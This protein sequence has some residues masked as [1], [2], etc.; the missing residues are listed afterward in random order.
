MQTEELSANWKTVVDTIQEGVMIVDPSGTIVSVNQAL[1]EMTGFGAARPGRPFLRR[2]QLRLLPAGAC[3]GRAAL[4]LVVRK[5]PA[6]PPALQPGAPRRH[7]GAGAQERLGAARRRRPGD[8]RGGDDHRPERSART[9]HHHRGLPAGVGQPR[10][11][12]R[13]GRG[14][15][16]HAAVL[17]PA[18]QRRLLGRAPAAPGRVGHGQG[19]GRA[20]RARAQSAPR[21]A[22]RQGQLRGP[23]RGPARERAVRPRARRLH[24]RAPGTGRPVRGGL[25]RHHL[26][27]RDRRFARAHP[28]QAA[29]RARGAGDRAGGR[30][31]AGG[32]WTCA[33]SRPPTATWRPWCARARFARTCSTASTSC[34]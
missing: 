20:G 3:A 12:P 8:R 6:H 10:H 27:R 17:R 9:R 32:R 24:R 1:A 30:Q 4:V 18:R 19:A 14:Q 22:V 7:R 25:G 23:Q 33:S 15:P 16:A 29:A 2:A 13:H 11:L 26:P 5:R 31:P 28:G 21:R 34:R